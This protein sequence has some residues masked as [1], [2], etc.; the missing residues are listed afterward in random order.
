MVSKRANA[1]LMKSFTHMSR[2]VGRGRC[3]TNPDVTGF[4]FYTVPTL[5]PF[6]AVR[7]LAGA[8]AVLLLA[9]SAPV[10]AQ[11]D[12]SSGGFEPSPAELARTRIRYGISLRNGGQADPGPG[13]SY[14]GLTPNDLGVEGAWFG[15]NPVGAWFS[16][17]R[18]A[19]S[20]TGDL[21]RLGGIGLWRV[22]LGP[23]ARLLFDRFLFEAS[24]GY[25]FSQLPTLGSTT[26][27]QMSS[28]QRHAALVTLRGQVELLYGLF[29]ELRAGAPIPISARSGPDAAARTFG[30]SAGAALSYRIGNAGRFTYA[31]VLDYEFV[32]DRIWWTDETGN[33][34]ASAQRMSRVGLA[35]EL[36]WLHRTPGQNLPRLGALGVVVLDAE[37]GAPLND[38]QVSVIPDPS[39]TAAAVATTREGLARFDALKE[40]NFR[41]EAV[42]PGYLATVGGAR[43]ESGD[44]ASLELKL[45]REP[46]R[47]GALAIKLVDALTKQPLAGAKLQSG[48]LSSVTNAQGEA[49]LEGLAP[50]AVSLTV[51]REGYL[52]GDE[53]ASVVAG[54]TSPVTLELAPEK[55][56]LPATIT[57]IVRSTRG[58]GPIQATLR[59]L[60][61]DLAE[62]TERNG[63]FRFQVPGGSYSVVIEA[64]GHLKQTKSVTVQDGAQAIFNVDLH[65][66]R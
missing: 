58:G 22:G 31:A 9:L 6:S 30:F 32:H 44:E 17:Q 40:G 15:R 53:A 43:I 27:P 52:D 36:S 37:S 28:A 38:A 54:K 59:V 16:V 4:H 12:F 13:A 49:L 63:T 26:A 24:A 45:T 42:A 65:P 50:G 10:G 56:K 64:P 18:E 21:G 47:F 19:F 25:Q 14:V 35:L 1:G 11:E 20:L 55:K 2:D 41:V 66:S 51:Q 3:V 8:C 46:P 23:A 61:L 39:T 62:Q 29:V 33:G 5:S 7:P 57:G 34:L 60:E 48:E